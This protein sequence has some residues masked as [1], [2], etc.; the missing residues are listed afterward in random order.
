ME[1]YEVTRSIVLQAVD[2]FSRQTIGENRKRPLRL[3]DYIPTEEEELGRKREAEDRIFESFLF[4][5][6]SAR[7]EQIDEAHAKTFDW[8]F[9]KPNAEQ[10]PWI[11]FTE[12]LETGEGIYWINGKA[13]SGKSTLMRYLLERPNTK[14]LLARWA[15]PISLDLASFFFWNAGTSYQ[16]SQ[17]ACY[18]HFCTKSSRNIGI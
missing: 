15:H 2:R 10:M 9:E 11:N 13:G 5:S 18:G 1:N 8:I 16:K 7:F 6:M 4:P 12:W 3:R 17:T 14:I